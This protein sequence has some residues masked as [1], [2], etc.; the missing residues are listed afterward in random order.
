MELDVVQIFDF[1]TGCNDLDGE[2]PTIEVAGRYPM[3]THWDRFESKLL[4]CRAVLAPG[5]ADRAKEYTNRSNGPVSF[6]M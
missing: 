3:Q 2:N 5:N 4:V 6:Y 1:N